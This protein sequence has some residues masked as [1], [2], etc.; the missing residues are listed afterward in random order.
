VNIG[1][2]D[3][4]LGLARKYDI[5]LDKGVPALVVLDGSGRVLYA[6]R[7]GEFEAMRRLDSS[8]VT[9][10]LQ[11]WKPTA[12]RRQAKRHPSSK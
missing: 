6:Q 3:K 2:Y 4:N 9:T 1:E 11:K 7:N 8:V 10:F 12:V 5:P